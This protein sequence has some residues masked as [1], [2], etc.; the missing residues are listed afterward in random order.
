[1][2]AVVTFR[3]DTAW[4]DGELIGPV[5][6]RCA[7]GRIA[8]IERV[9]DQAR[10]RG[11]GEA[12]IDL[13]GLVLPGFADAHSH[14]FHRAL[15]GRTHGQRQHG[16]RQPGTFWTWR[17]QMYA[18]AG[19]LDPDSLY[20]LAVAAYAEMICA[21]VTAVG[22][23]HYLHHDPQGRPYGD[24]NAMGLA[25]VAAATETGIGLTLIDV[26]YLA[27]GFGQ[28]VS[29]VQRRFSDGTAQAWAE[30]QAALSASVP[31]TIARTGVA[32]HSVRAVPVADLPV[33]ARAAAG[34]PLHVHLSEQPAENEAARAATGH[35]PTELLAAAGALGARTSAVHATHLTDG[36]VGLL[37]DA[38]ATAVICPT[39]EADLADG[40]PAASKMAAAGMKLA[41][42]SDQHVVTDPLA[43]MR[44]LEWGERLATGRRGNF[45]PAELVEAATVTSHR[46][47]GSAAGRLQVGAPADLVCLDR[48]ST[49]TAGADG[50]QLVMA[51][52]AADVRVVV[53]GGAVC[54]RDGRHERLGPPGPLL[55]SA[56]E[57]AWHR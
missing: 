16:Q 29:G 34:G 13:P 11:P 6:I 22:E 31:S 27:G 37:G 40:L 53:I 30:R 19:G 54:A 45:T 18:L 24:P 41:L 2:T 25:L 23:F 1:M 50:L 5:D 3:A 44:G 10:P 17:E 43:Q 47:I 15:R 52:G 14:V 48:Y 12:R 33:V 26:A 4:V 36:D 20:H 21:G 8:A 7:A 55:R 49:R 9:D 38:G 39:T 42:G 57:R 28:P 46:S 32:I 56:I 35:T 51:A